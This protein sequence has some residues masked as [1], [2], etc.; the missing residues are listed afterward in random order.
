MAATLTAINGPPAR[1]E[2]L[3]TEWASSSFPVPV[4]PTISTGLSVAAIFSNIFLVRRM[5]SDSPNTSSMVYF[6]MCP[7]FSS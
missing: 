7:F 6:A 5:Q 3:C 1:R 2:A 4:S